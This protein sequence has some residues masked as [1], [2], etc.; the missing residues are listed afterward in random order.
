MIVGAASF[1]VPSSPVVPLAPPRVT[2]M[3]R[4]IGTVTIVIIA[5]RSVSVPIALAAETSCVF[6]VSIRRGNVPAFFV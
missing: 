3:P 6:T 1:T 4:T 5:G 2:G